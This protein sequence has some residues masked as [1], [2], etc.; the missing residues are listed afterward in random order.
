MI[1]WAAADIP[2]PGAVAAAEVAPAPAAA[3][4]DAVDPEPGDIPG[5]VLGGVIAA[6]ARA[7]GPVAV[8]VHRLSSVLV[9]TVG[10]SSPRT[11]SFS[12]TTDSR[13]GRIA[14][15]LK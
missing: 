14:S 5:P 3:R 8:A 9:R 11:P 1:V 7:R 6:A 2:G 13:F 12:E 10:E 4:G 15:C